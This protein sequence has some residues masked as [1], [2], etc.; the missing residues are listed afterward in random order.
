MRLAVEVTS[1]TPDRT[2]VGYYTEHLADALIASAGPDDDLVLIGNRAVAP[3]LARRWAGRLHIGGARRRYLWIQTDAGRL[4]EQTRTDL[5]LFP[6]YLAPLASPCPYVNVIHDMAIYRTPQFFTLRKRAVVGALLPLVTR[7]AAAVATVSESS[8][9]DVRQLLAVPDD[10]LVL[11]PG[12]PHPD[13]RPA[14]DA[15]VA[16]MRARHGLRRP[17][18]LTVG[19]LEPRKNLPL[20]LRAFDRLSRLA[21]SVDLVVVGGK[22][23]YDGELRAELARRLPAGRVHVLGYVSQEDLVALYSGA[24]A[25]AYPSHFEG[26][27]LP[28]VEAMACGA[29]VVATDVPALREAS[30]GAA[31]LVPPGDDAALAEALRLLIV[32][33]DAR[34]RACQL[35]LRRAAE[36][37]WE[38]SAARLWALARQIR[39][40][41]SSPTSVAVGGTV[42]TPGRPLGADL[43]DWAI[44]ATVTYADLF[45][46]PVSDAEIAR[47]CLG[48]RM[49]AAE[50]RRRATQAPLAQVVQLH[51][52][53][54]L[55][56]LG[57]DALVA[58]RADGIAR[59]A[60]LLDR[61]RAV[62][63]ALASLP[64]VRMLALSGGTAHRNAR[65]G[66]DIDLFVVA[67]AGRVFT[68]YTML[69]L[70]SRLTRT[71]GIV[72]PNY[73]VDEDNLEIA[74]HHDLFT[75]HQALSLVPI[76]G[77][78]T[79]GRL[80]A[81]NRDWV[82][83]FFPGFE[84]R[85]PAEVATPARAQR[86]AERALGLGGRA[87]EQTL[88]AAWRYRL[89]RRAARARSADVVLSGGVLKM[90]LSDHRRR[91]LARFQQRLDE[92][93]AGWPVA[94]RSTEAISAEAIS[95]SG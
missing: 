25:M 60:A 86:W 87:V 73:V 32:D 52:T 4:L 45:D 91:V 54:D 19:T 83:A 59:T 57:R 14:G 63:A 2:G 53:G 6:N 89:G 76:A 7:G 82:R 34:A 37:S 42:P 49:D 1:C 36:L 20:L 58:R 46:A 29:P 64:F 75:A 35:G 31:A 8:R 5:A 67:A 41:R 81:A 16:A 90:H 39:G 94:E 70:A 66:D 62:I 95:A 28:V 15:A 51:P 40:A 71:R 21:P 93:A 50:V 72:C 44:A 17:Y 9:A 79:F 84:P 78:P 38:A 24:V 26:F 68:A 92:L 55:T 11:L 56:L 85:E 3:E 61:H 65:G 18:L 74:F 27:G 30:G 43:R 88:G 13:C 77:L 47:G 22:G 10:R 69:F 80:V 12:A 33:P 23:W 48:A